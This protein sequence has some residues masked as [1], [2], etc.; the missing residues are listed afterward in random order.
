MESD[1][2]K[3]KQSIT[4]WPALFAFAQ[5]YTAKRARSSLL[6]RA[7]GDVFWPQVLQQGGGIIE[8][9]K[10]L[11]EEKCVQPAPAGATGA[12]S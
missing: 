3:L 2:E 10:L 7:L 12:Y 9:A 6:P 4:D 11:I 5:A 1:P 8:K